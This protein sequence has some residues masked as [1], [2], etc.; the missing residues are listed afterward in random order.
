M[1]TAQYGQHGQL[2]LALEHML[3]ATGL[4]SFSVLLQPAAYSYSG[5][6]IAQN[7]VNPFQT[8]IQFAYGVLQL[9][10]PGGLRSLLLILRLFGQFLVAGPVHRAEAFS[11]DRVRM[12]ERGVE[13]VSIHRGQ[14]LDLKLQ[15]GS[16][17]LL[18]VA[19][20]NSERV[21]ES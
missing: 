13:P 2:H 6:P 10:T 16:T 9:V 4:G 7:G 5:L 17:E 14:I 8:L 19:E 15:E 12:V 3:S 11:E 21:C 1:F 18:A 20:I